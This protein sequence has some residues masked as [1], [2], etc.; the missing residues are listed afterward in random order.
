MA[1]TGDALFEAHLRLALEGPGSSSVVVAG[2]AFRGMLDQEDATVGDP[3]G[4][5]RE[6]SR[7]LLRVATA[8]LTGLTVARE[9]TC[10][11]DGDNYVIRDVDKE[12]DGK[13]TVLAV[14]AT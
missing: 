9:T 7:R 5:Y 8:R 11:I 14:V 2:K 3:G 13:V 1:I 10:T 4:G 12:G 6:R